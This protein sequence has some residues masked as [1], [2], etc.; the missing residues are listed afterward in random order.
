MPEL[1]ENGAKWKK[2]RR[3]FCGFGLMRYICGK[4]DANEKKSYIEET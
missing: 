2:E 1:C 4:L 3:K